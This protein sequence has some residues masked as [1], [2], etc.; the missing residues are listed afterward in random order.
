MI[1]LIGSSTVDISIG[2]SFVD[3][4]ATCT[5]DIDPTC[6]VVSTGTVDT[7]QSGT[8]MIMY[9]AV[10]LAGNAALQVV[11]TVNVSPVLDV[12]PPSITL[13]GSSIL[14]TP[15]GSTFI[16]PGATCTDNVGCSVS[17][18]GS[19]NTSSI[20]TYT[21]E[22]VASDVAG[23]TSA[24][25]SRTVYV[26]DPV[27][28]NIILN[29]S[30]VIHLTL[31][32]TFV[33]SGAVW[34]DMTDGD[35]VI[36]SASGAVNTTATGS[37]VITYTYINSLGN[38]GTLSR[39]IIISDVLPVPDTT[40]PSVTLS[41]STTL[42]LEAGSGYTDDGAFWTDNTDGS[43]NTLDTTFTLSGLTYLTDHLSIPGV[44]TLM[45]TKVDASGNSGS[46]NRTIT[47]QDTTAPTLTVNGSSTLTLL[48]GEAYTESGAL[49]SDTVDG[50]GILSTPFSGSVDTSTLGT[51]LLTY[52][53]VDSSNNTGT[54]TRTVHVRARV[55]PPV[56]ITSVVGPGGGGGGSY[57]YTPFTIRPLISSG[58]T[59]ILVSSGSTIVPPVIPQNTKFQLLPLK[60]RLKKINRTNVLT[61]YNTPF[62]VKDSANIFVYRSKDEASDSILMFLPS[63]ETLQ[64]RYIDQNGW[65]LVTLSNGSW[66][67]VRS[68][69]IEKI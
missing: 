54:T 15:V 56:I 53:Y 62:R 18:S 11:R 41:G 58:L 55:T 40:P 68:E 20:G 29:G 64:V 33:D 37:Y 36:S 17:V 46:T 27:I 31:G 19:V 2:D 32:D 14:I 57:G 48:Q 22:Y 9:D 69:L 39:T 21:Y 7:S 25:I 13:S 66:G 47:I 61:R 45:Y 28:P 23:N 65:A 35:G 43:G 49:W 5:D 44:Y 1:T 63:G 6:V 8:Y 16:D 67:F 30:S 50:S 24:T 59:M 26:V 60:E 3:P 10:D 42:T 34:V 12:T 51:Y 4:G 52:Q 38:T